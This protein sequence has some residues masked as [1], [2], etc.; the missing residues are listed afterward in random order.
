MLTLFISLLYNIIKFYLDVIAL[1]ANVRLPLVLS[2]LRYLNDN[3]T[4]NCKN[5]VKENLHKLVIKSSNGNF[6]C[7]T[8]VVVV[9][10]S[11]SS[12]F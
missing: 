3:F 5:F 10:Y 7:N 4:D 6:V 11:K 2:L 1:N 12:E 8:V 9:V